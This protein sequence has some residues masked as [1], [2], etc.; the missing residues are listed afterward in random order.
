MEEAPPHF[1]DA[2]NSL[3]NEVPDELRMENPVLFSV[4]PDE[5]EVATNNKEPTSVHAGTSSMKDEQ[6]DVSEAVKAAAAAA[7]EAVRAAGGSEEVAESAAMSAAEEAKKAEADM[8]KVAEA[9]AR[10]A[11]AEAEKEVELPPKIVG[12]SGL[13]E[14]NNRFAGEFQRSFSHRSVRC[15][16]TH[17]HLRSSMRTTPQYNL[18]CL[19]LCYL[20]QGESSGIKRMF[21]V[22][23]ASS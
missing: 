23:P 17:R 21:E 1:P 6:L 15:A 18:M 3:Q 5:E 4:A 14:G 16:C 19:P 10:K 12:H 20:I 8:A 11:A 13:F 7:R 22:L 9:E 2:P